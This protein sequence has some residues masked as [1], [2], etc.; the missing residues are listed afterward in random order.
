MDTTFCTSNQAAKLLN[1]HPNTLRSW[2]D[3][4]IIQ[5]FRSTD[6]GHRRYN[7]QEFLSKRN[8]Q[9]EPP[10]IK[11]NICYCRVSSR[12]QK[13]E[14]KNQIEYL[15]SKYPNHDIITDIAS[16]LNYKR[17][18]LQ[19]ILDY[20]KQGIIGQIVVTFKDRMCRFGFELIQYVVESSGGEILVLNQLESSPQEEMVKDLTSIIHIFSCRLYGLRRYK[21]TIK[22]ASKS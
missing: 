2:E 18:G 17:K 14:L 16:G 1:I 7:I 3:K 22:E 8:K 19:K 9:E 15:K 10:I 4:N 12:N 21:K 6:K 20:A 5:S 11:K 13:E